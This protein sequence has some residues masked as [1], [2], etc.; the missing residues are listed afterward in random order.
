MGEVKVGAA[1]YRALAGMMGR[2]AVKAHAQAHRA[3]F[4]RLEAS[5]TRLAEAAEKLEAVPSSLEDVSSPSETPKAKVLR[6]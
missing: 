4:L 3:A 2:L 6:G 5:W 1:Y